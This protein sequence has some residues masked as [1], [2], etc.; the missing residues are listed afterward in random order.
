[1]T[2]HDDQKKM[3]ADL[4]QPGRRQ[5]DKGAQL[6]ANNIRETLTQ[7][8]RDSY[9]MAHMLLGEDY[10]RQ[11]AHAY[12]ALSPPVSGDLNL[13]GDSFADFLKHLPGMVDYLYVPDIAAMEWLAHEAALQPLLK[14]DAGAPP[15]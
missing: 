2:L 13:Y 6:H 4:L 3:L 1:M 12:I 14:A 10:F 7:S 15:R 5:S 11:S 9:P 8:L